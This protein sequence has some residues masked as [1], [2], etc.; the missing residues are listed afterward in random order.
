MNK[1]NIENKIKSNAVMRI[2][3]GWRLHK[4]NN[5]LNLLHKFD[6]SQQSLDLNFD[7]FT[8]IMLN[9]DLT[10][11]VANLI[12]YIQY[13]VRVDLKI[14]NRVLLTSY[15]FANYPN[16]ILGEETQR[17]PMSA[18]I[19][20]LSKEL[21]NSLKPN[22][23]LELKEHVKLIGENMLNYSITF[24]VWKMQ[25]KAKMIQSMMISYYHREEHIRKIESGE[26]SVNEND[27]QTPKAE[28]KRQQDDILQSIRM[29]DRSFD[30]KYFE[31]NYK[32][33]C[34]TMEQDYQ[35]LQV[36]LKDTMKIAYFDY[37]KDGMKK[38]DYSP[39]LALFAEIREKLLNIMTNQ[40]AKD[41]FTTY[42]N[43]EKLQEKI[44]LNK[45]ENKHLI[46]CI[47]HIVEAIKSLQAPIDDESHTEWKET[48]VKQLSKDS[49]EDF[50][51]V[52]P[53]ILIQAEERID[54]IYKD[55]LE[56][57]KQK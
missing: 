46:V 3:R 55:I 18:R 48:I 29:M 28:L 54:K 14:N 17:D 41:V 34:E 31:K 45:L 5:F 56:L 4:A 36:N 12:Y 20:L 25:D 24:S 33:I 51:E 49:S 2:Q 16:E 43:V 52:V 11:I 9:K 7:D 13:S 22:D 38:G 15:L 27:K 21:I 30:I 26:L 32:L 10:T 44:E 42:V 47:I 6:L 37:V 19:H 35:K 8:K 1:V 50:C 57:S 39:V 23:N 40:E 53:E